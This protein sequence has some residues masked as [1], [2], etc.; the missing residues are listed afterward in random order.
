MQQASNPKSVAKKLA[1]V[2]AASVAAI[3]LIIVFSNPE[4][5]LMYSD[6]AAVATV[7]TGL[8]FS[9]VVVS[10]QK[11]DGLH[12]KTYA[13]V[14]IGLS[15]WIVAEVIWAYYE[16]A[17]EID[18]PFPSIADAFWLAGYLPFAYHIFRTYRFFGKVIK[19]YTTAIV[20]AGAAI[21]LGYAIT[22][23]YF[24]TAEPL[25]D[26]ASFS[27]GIAYPIL[28]AVLIVPAIAILLFM[29]KGELTS[30][31]WMLLSSAM[32]MYA[33]GDS[34]FAFDALLSLTEEIWIWNIFYNA[35]DLCVAG[36]LFWHN[37]FLVLYERRNKA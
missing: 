20:A 1:L 21:F 5:R 26:I 10:R 18:T 16:I 28:D 15:F 6:M 9:L 7:S 30:M 8:A 2:L 24:A 19:P 25:S 36:A 22:M 17:L 29:G 34:G 31:P 33:V 37:R 13:A 3:N 27:L 12:G 4:S 14:A 35:G 23:I 32:I 11:L